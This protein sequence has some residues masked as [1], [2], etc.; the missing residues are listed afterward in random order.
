MGKLPV[1]IS[2]GVQKPEREDDY[3]FR[4]ST[5]VNA[6]SYIYNF[7]S[8]HRGSHYASAGTMSFSEICQ[9]ITVA[10]FPT[11]PQ[12]CCSNVSETQV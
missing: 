4:T 5:A 10:V 9:V 1:V 7:A 11:L 12:G 2:P 8:T 6:W 3:S